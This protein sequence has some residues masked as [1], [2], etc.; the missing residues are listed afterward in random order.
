MKLNKLA[1]ATLLSLM[2]ATAVDANAQQY[3]NV[4]YTAVV[5]DINY[6]YKQESPKDTGSK[7]LQ[8]GKE[9]LTGQSSQQLEGY[10]DA[11]RQAVVSGMSEVYRLR[12]TDYVGEGCDYYID[13]DISNITT[14]DKLITPTDK[15]K[16]A[17][18]G[19]KA[20]IRVTVN[21]KVATDGSVYDSYTFNITEYSSS[22]WFDTKETAVNKAL[23][24]LTSNVRSY[25]KH[26]FPIYA[27]VEE[28]GEAKK[29]KLKELYI[30]LGSNFGVV[31]GDEFNVYTITTIGTKQARSEIGRVKVTEVMGEDISRCK[32]NKGSDKV[33]AA[34]DQGAQLQLVSR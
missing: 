16:K 1:A 33:K 9:M 31:K 10:A 28:I 32:V 24:E 8:F 3:E 26:L 30:D 19:Y 17:F 20:Q 13:G 5:S 27:K 7:I 6:T 25:Y 34:L 22:Q 18:T 23:E 11:V 21:L 15:A 2:V 29:D 14:T 12:I 4:V